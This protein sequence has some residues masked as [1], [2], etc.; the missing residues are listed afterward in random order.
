MNA[1]IFNIITPDSRGRSV[2]ALGAFL[3]IWQ[4]L[5]LSAVAL[6]SP[7]K[8][9]EASETGFA[10]EL[11]G[12]DIIEHLGEKVPGDIVFVT[13]EGDTVTMAETLAET[14][15]SGRP[16]VLNLA[17]YECPMLC[18]LV[19]N[20]ISE[21]VGKL[22]WNAGDKFQMLTVSIKPSET[23]E[24]AAA[25]KKNYLENFAEKSSRTLDPAGWTFAVAEESQSQALAEAVGFKYY[26][27][28]E[29][30]EYAHAAV[31]II[32][33]PEGMIS[34]Y[35]YGI[36][37]RESDIRLALLEASE[38]KIGN[39]VDRLLL[40][41]FR[42]D[43]DARGYVLFASNVMKLGGALTVF[44][45]LFVVGGFWLKERARSRQSQSSVT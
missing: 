17:Y 26:R 31:T 6:P 5:T 37:H 22:N 45:M 10:P 34:R 28:P 15:K 35:L 11:E 13:S 14:T 27:V 16:I 40:Y 2:L 19:L 4:L 23:A 18:N 41:C 24:L 30:G 7:P 32:L 25:K 36:E 33:S 44:V 38:G 3:L 42:Y 12:I 1:S 21:S 20:G 8:T 39:T 43:P 29:T 9:G